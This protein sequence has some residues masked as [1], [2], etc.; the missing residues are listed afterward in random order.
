MAAARQWAPTFCAAPPGWPA[1]LL[2]A[3]PWRSSP[4]WCPASAPPLPTGAYYST[5]LRRVLD[6]AGDGGGG[7]MLYRADS[8]IAIATACTVLMACWSTRRC[9]TPH[10]GMHEITYMVCQLVEALGRLRRLPVLTAT[11]L[12]LCLVPFVIRHAAA[13]LLPAGWPT[14]GDCLTT[15]TGVAQGSSSGQCTCKRCAAAPGSQTDHSHQTRSCPGAPAARDVAVTLCSSG[16]CAA[17]KWLPSRFDSHGRHEQ[18]LLDGVCQRGGQCKMTP[19][20]CCRPARS[21]YRLHACCTS[22]ALHPL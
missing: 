12:L 1:V 7:V 14:R 19:A 5:S 4:C 22:A 2:R 13:L 6:E 16:R 17:S 9:I 3:P 15:V 11:I 18:R 8:G 21:E 20:N 10:L